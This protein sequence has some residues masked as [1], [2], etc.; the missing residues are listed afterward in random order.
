MTSTNQ[1][2]RSSL[3][4]L[5]ARLPARLEFGDVLIFLYTLVFTRQYFWIISNNSIAWLL[6]LVV[7]VVLWVFYVSSKQ[8]PRE[9][10]PLS[11][12]LVV[13]LPL[14]AFF[15]LRAAFPD[16]SFDV[17]TYHLLHS[18]RT[19]RGP[20][21]GA[22]DYFPSPSPYNPA[23]DTLAGLSRL[24]LG[25]RLGPAINLLVLIW[26]AQITDNLLRPLVT[27]AWLRSG[28]VL[29]IVMAENF[30]FEISTYMIDLLALPL[31]MQATLLCLRADEAESERANFIQI[32]LLLGASVAFKLTNLAVALP[33]VAICIYQISKQRLWRRPKEIGVIAVTSLI[34]FLAPQLPFFIYIFRLTGNPL[35]PIANV[36]FKSPY[37]PT[38]GGWDDRWGPHTFWETIAWPILIWF[39][40]GRHSELAVYSGRLSLSFIVA[41]IGLF[42]VWR[43]QRARLLCLIL[44]VSALLWSVAGMGY[45]RYG[46]YQELLAGT[47]SVAVVMVL[48]RAGS[49]WKRAIAVAVCALLVGQAGLAAAYTLRHEWGARTSAVANPDKYRQEIGFALRDHSLREFLSNDMR[50][51]F[52]D[53]QVWLET[54][55]E[56]TGFEALL[57]PAAPIIAGRQPEYFFTREAR[58]RF[59]QAV[60]AAPAP[61][62]FSVCF[63]KYTDVCRQAIAARGLEIARTTPV[64]VPF[65][66]PQDRIG[67]M[68]IEIDRPL[69]GEARSKFESMWMNAAFPDSDYREQIT[70]LNAPPEMHAGEKITIRFRVRNLGYSAWPFQGNKEGRYQVNLANRWLNKAGQTEPSGAEGRTAMK[71]DLEPGGEVELPLLVT[72]PTAT[73]EFTMEVDM[74]HEGVTWFYERGARPLQLRVRV[75]P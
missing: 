72:A 67:M 44:I 59:I 43:N 50:R 42:F 4:G 37:W 28:F 64:E 75:V 27:N 61:R 11:F 12:W 58:R 23:P 68:L 47:T 62:M 18:E 25:F 15:L 56:S 48:F 60:E 65:F 29:I 71:S 32:A 3:P 55:P 45:S 14:V 31:M 57:N 40:P 70:A 35:F 46:L 34:A 9:K 17:L 74:V 26:A 21:F 36:F 1:Q 16:H 66:S 33:L 24:V 19:L 5:F 20:L 38:H 69:D 49:I 22:G 52:D 41:L 13:G 30:F 39:K 51:T 73:G 54:C 53:V 63:A 10:T 2:P 7:A 8:F 6:S